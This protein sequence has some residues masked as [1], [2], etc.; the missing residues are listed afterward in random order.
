MAKTATPTP[1]TQ[2]R[3]LTEFY[4][5]APLATV[6]TAHE[7]FTELLARRRAQASTP[8][9][10]DPTSDGRTAGIA[11][12]VAPVAPAPRRGPGRPRRSGLPAPSP[13]AAGAA[14]TPTPLPE[15]TAPDA[16]DDDEI[17]AASD[18]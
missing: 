1:A 4:L 16:D 2:L 11:A 5:T 15:Q 12:P 7:I 10:I 8:P 3:A 18:R 17:L 14:P 9:P 13:A 6:E